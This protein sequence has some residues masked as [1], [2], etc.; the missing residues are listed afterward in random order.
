MRVT[1]VYACARLRASDEKL[2]S[3]AA[4]QDVLFTSLRKT[5]GYIYTRRPHGNHTRSR[6]SPES[7]GRTYVYSS[8]IPV[9]AGAAL[10]C[11]RNARGAEGSSEAPRFCTI[12]GRSKEKFAKPARP[13]GRAKRFREF[14][15]LCN[16]ARR[17]VRCLAGSGEKR[18]IGENEVLIVRCCIERK[19]D[20]NCI[21]L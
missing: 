14:V 20:S 19:R 8:P 3:R 17:V 10:T 21:L 9:E 4:P 1:R 2:L 7:P 13:S 12:R 15:S 18:G 5:P 11:R 16:Q 6:K